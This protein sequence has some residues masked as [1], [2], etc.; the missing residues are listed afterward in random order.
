MQAP[1]LCRNTPVQNLCYLSPD[2]LRLRKYK[3][4][5]P[6]G[7]DYDTK[8]RREEK[9]TTNSIADTKDNKPRSCTWHPDTI[10]RTEIVFH[11]QWGVNFFDGNWHLESNKKEKKKERKKGCPFFDI[12]L[13]LFSHESCIHRSGLTQ[14]P[15][16]LAPRHVRSVCEARWVN[17]FT[18]SGQFIP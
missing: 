6:T 17:V 7:N 11:T 2:F 3:R 4:R 18:T 10:A 14:W 8:C 9:R 12:Y 5:T 16:P 1:R 13:A 15:W